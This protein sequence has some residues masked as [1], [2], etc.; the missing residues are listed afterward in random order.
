MLQFTPRKKVECR[1]KALRPR[2][3]NR[4][5]VKGP[6]VNGCV[7]LFYSTLAGK[8]MCMRVC[9]VSTKEVLSLSR[10][11]LNKQSLPYKV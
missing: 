2:T 5:T 4:V 6:T 3:N 8:Q 10:A 11:L 7:T 9:E 1:W